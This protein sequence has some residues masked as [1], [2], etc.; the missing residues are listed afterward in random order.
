VRALPGAWR[1]FDVLTDHGVRWTIATSGQ[2]VGDVDEILVHDRAAG[3]LGAGAVV[4][5]GYVRAGVV[6]PVGTG[7][8]QR[9]TG[10]EVPV[11]ERAERLA[12]PC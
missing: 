4:Q 8:G 3:D 5:P 11:A 6:H 2:P 12:Q 9:S 1:L 7:L 10:H